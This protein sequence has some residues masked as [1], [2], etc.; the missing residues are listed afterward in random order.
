MKSAFPKMEFLF[1]PEQT[2]PFLRR[3]ENT[4][5]QL[6]QAAAAGSPA[7]K[8]RAAAALG[9]FGHALNLVKELAELR[10]RAA[11]EATSAGGLR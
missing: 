4:C 8:E 6:R 10:N 1:D 5:K 2:E 11:G 7:E 3:I 9:A